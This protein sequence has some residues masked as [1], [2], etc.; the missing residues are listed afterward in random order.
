MHWVPELKL[1][2]DYLAFTQEW[3]SL[4]LTPRNHPHSNSCPGVTV[5][6]DLVAKNAKGTITCLV[7]GT[8]NAPSISFKDS[9]GKTMVTATGITV[10]LGSW[11]KQLFLI[12]VKRHR[13]HARIY[14]RVIN[15]S[16][17]VI[18][19]RIALLWKCASS[20]RSLLYIVRQKGMRYRNPPHLRLEDNR[21]HSWNSNPD[22]STCSCMNDLPPLTISIHRIYAISIRHNRQEADGDAWSS[23]RN[24]RRRVQLC[25][26]ILG[27]HQHWRS[28][29][30]SQD[31]H[32]W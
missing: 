24:C 3:P 1:K 10:N 28:S 31:H 6:P 4:P 2:D 22:Q 15:Y 26:Q 20:V 19:I 18:H 11:S 17:V 23:L 30:Q 5:T 9:T 27:V 12:I 16:P 14:E 32:V 21:M 13:K 8:D 7:D 25:S 29:R